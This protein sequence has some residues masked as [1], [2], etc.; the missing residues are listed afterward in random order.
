L[1]AEEWVEVGGDLY[2]AHY[3]G[4]GMAMFAGPIHNNI[5]ECQCENAAVLA[6]VTSRALSVSSLKAEA[7]G[8]S[9]L[10]NA[11]AGRSKR[12]IK[13]SLDQ[14]VG[15]T[16]DFSICG[17]DPKGAFLGDEEPDDAQVITGLEAL[18]AALLAIPAEVAAS[19]GSGKAKKK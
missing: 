7:R 18:P 3:P 15:Y 8:N 9:Q 11:S 1:S 16:V 4:I 10:R 2:I 19:V 13:N 14:T 17:T 6:E 5:W 12:A